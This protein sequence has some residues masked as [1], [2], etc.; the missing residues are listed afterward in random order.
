MQTS[1]VL[2]VDS[3]R[4]YQDEIWPIG[5]GCS[6]S[7]SEEV[8]CLEECILAARKS[9]QEGNSFNPIDKRKMLDNVRKVAAV[10]VRCM[11]NHGSPLRYG[12]V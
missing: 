5:T 2:S 3:E 7:V 1:V 10:A 12:K 9:C 4:K 11:E 6:R 8:L